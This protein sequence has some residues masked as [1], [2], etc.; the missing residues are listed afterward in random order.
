MKRHVF[1]GL[2]CSVLAWPA[3]S[4]AQQLPN[5]AFKRVELAPI[6][7][8]DASLTII[9][10]SG[11]EHVYLPADLE[12]LPT[13]ALETVTPWREEPA[14]FEG[15]MLADLLARHGLDQLDRIFVLAENDYVTEIDRAA[16][17][18]GALMVATRVNGEPHSRRA[19]GPIQFVVPMEMLEA[20]R[21]IT[22][23]HLVWMAALIRP[24]D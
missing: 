7:H 14:L 15:I 23:Q 8:S 4:F 19:R 2:V 22:S 11:T 3:A 5:A 10:P 12:A 13:Y 16:L 1:A 21:E 18:A 6:A 20:E 24:A 17:Q 9:D